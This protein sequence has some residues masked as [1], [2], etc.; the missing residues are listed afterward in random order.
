MSRPSP[1]PAPV[2]AAERFLGPLVLMFKSL[3]VVN[4]ESSIHFPGRPLPVDV[5]LPDFLGEQ[6]RLTVRSE[7]P[8]SDKLKPILM[9]VVELM[10]SAYEPLTAASRFES[11][12]NCA[13]I[14]VPDG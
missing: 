13:M 2:I 12:P 8:L 3:L 7:G 5:L 9:G 1:L 14:T 10:P 4:Q 6:R 11:T